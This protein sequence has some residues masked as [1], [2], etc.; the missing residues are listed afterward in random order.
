[1][2]GNIDKQHIPLIDP[3]AHLTFDQFQGEEEAALTRAWD[4]GLQAIVLIGAGRGIEGNRRAL[5]FSKTDS[6]LF[7]AVGVHPNDVEGMTDEWLQEIRLAAQ[8]KKVVAIGEIGLDYFRQHA[9][10]E[11]QF[12]WFERHIDLAKEANLPII[13]HNRDASDDTLRVLQY[14]KPPSKCGVFHAFPGDIAFA[15]K[16]LDLGFFI[17]ITGVV[18]FKNAPTLRDMVKYVPLDRIMIE[19]DCPY[20]APEP[21]RGLR[22]EPSYIPL[23][24]EKIAE[25]KGISVEEVARVTTENAKNLLSI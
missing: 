10:K 17:S 21:H 7:V 25:V 22:N 15:Q 12:F 3:H 23:I 5:E 11:K 14:V 20:L 4:A 2:K 16:V 6:R 9:A 18:T 8:E 13:I 19:T 24:A 1:M